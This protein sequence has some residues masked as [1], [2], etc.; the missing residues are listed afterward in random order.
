LASTDHSRELNGRI[1]LTRGEG[2]ERRRVKGSG[3]HVLVV[4]KERGQ[5]GYSKTLKGPADQIK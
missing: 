3:C 1:L 2:E 5:R 4:R